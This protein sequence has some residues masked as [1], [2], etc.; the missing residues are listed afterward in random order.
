MG[1]FVLQAFPCSLDVM[2]NAAVPHRSL[3]IVCKIKKLEF[4]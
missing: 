1:M 2:I 4:V 3:E